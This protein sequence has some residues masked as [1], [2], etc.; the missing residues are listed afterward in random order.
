MRS[1][2]ACIFT[3]LPTPSRC[4]RRGE[5]DGMTVPTLVLLHGRH[6][7]GEVRAGEVG[8]ADRLVD[9]LVD[10]VVAG[11][12]CRTWCRRRRR[13]ASRSPAPGP[14][15]RAG[16][17]RALEAVDRGL[18][19]DHQRRVLAERLVR[20]APPRRRGPRTCT[21]RTSHCGAGRP[22][23][24]RGDVAR[25]RSTSAGSRVD[26][27]PDVVRE[28]RR[29]DQVVVAVHGV[30]AVED[31]DLQPGGQRRAWKPSTMS[32]QPRACSGSAPSRRRTAPSRAGRSRSATG[33]RRPRP[34]RPGSSGRPSRP[35][36]SGPAGRGPWRRPAAA[37]RG[38]A[39]RWRR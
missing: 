13:S 10:R 24:L 14:A 9:A 26:A 3:G 34:A 6:V 15:G 37:S 5:Y 29:A 21:A 31:R 33:R 23:L 1:W 39:G 25:R 7:R 8:P 12:R 19:R 38:T 28:D 2:W 35:A 11:R 16:T 32:A 22:D 27:E 17:R 18:H 4:S 20:A 30:D 36:S